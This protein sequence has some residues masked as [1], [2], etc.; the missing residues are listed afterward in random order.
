MVTKVGD[1]SI[2][3]FLHDRLFNMLRVISQ[4]IARILL[5]R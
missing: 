1:Q 4:K 5:I 2:A 3:L